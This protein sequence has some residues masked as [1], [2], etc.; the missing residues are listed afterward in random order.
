MVSP[1]PD[2]SVHTIDPRKH[3][4]IIIGSDGLWN[5]VSAQDAVSLCQELEKSCV[6]VSKHVLLP[7]SI[8]PI[9]L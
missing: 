1:E 8:T 4:F 5:M 6:S 2:T 7:R 3:K 9:Y